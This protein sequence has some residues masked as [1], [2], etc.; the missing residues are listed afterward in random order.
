MHWQ[1]FRGIF[2]F[3]CIFDIM[4]GSGSAQTGRRTDEHDN[5]RSCVQP[6]AY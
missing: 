5:E 2:V 4:L 3:L 1:T 6:A